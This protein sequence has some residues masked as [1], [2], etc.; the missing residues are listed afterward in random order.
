MQ[1]ANS[2]KMLLLFELFEFNICLAKADKEIILKFHQPYS[3]KNI[4]E[5]IW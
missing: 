3:S 5:I 4:A 1:T 2:S